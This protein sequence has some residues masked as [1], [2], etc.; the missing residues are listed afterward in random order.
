MTSDSRANVNAG[1]ASVAHGRARWNAWFEEMTRPVNAW[2]CAKTRLAPGMT[3]L[4]IASGT[5]QP[6]LT[7]ARIIGPTGRM[8]G[9]DIAHE[10]VEAAS[11]LA[12]AEDLTN[13]EFRQ[14]DAQALDFPDATF[15]AAVSRWGVMFP[16]D[17]AKALGELFRV[18]KPGARYAAAFWDDTTKNPRQSFLDS[19]IRKALGEPPRE[20]NAGGVAY[21]YA[22]PQPLVDLLAQT[23]FEIGE[24]ETVTFAYDF[25][26]VEDFWQGLQEAWPSGRLNTLSPEQRARVE[27]L[28]PAEAERFRAGDLIRLPS[29][30]HCLEPAT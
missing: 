21:R 19:V 6:G 17:Q 16:E 30:N 26:S 22:N 2:L 7:A 23:G 9:I 5:G 25:D 14:M 12:A 10:M 3:V 13:T 15:D 27:A 24:L 11:G 4:D 29:S 20:T 18:L 1:W 8:V 28:F